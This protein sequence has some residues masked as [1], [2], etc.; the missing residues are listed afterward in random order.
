MQDAAVPDGGGDGR[1]VGDVVLVGVPAGGVEVEA[2]ADA[3]GV[4]AQFGGERRADLELGGGEYGAEAEFGGGSRGAG[5]EEGFGLFGGEPGEAGAVA[6]DEP[7]SAG[8]PGVAVEGYARCVQGVDVAVHGA[9]GDVECGGELG[10]GHP[11]AGLEQQQDGHQS[12]G[13]H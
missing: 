5:E 12:A 13:L 10:G 7:V 1:E 3:F 9:Y 8:V 11:A 4:G 6:V 2:G